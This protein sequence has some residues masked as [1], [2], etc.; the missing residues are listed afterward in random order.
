M[1][2]EV[3]LITSS[4]DCTIT[5]CCHNN[6]SPCNPNST[7]HDTGSSQWHGASIVHST[8]FEDQSDKARMPLSGADAIL[9]KLTEFS[10]RSYRAQGNVL[11]LPIS[12]VVNFK[13]PP[14]ARTFE[15][16]VKGAKHHF[17][18]FITRFPTPNLKLGNL[19]LVHSSY[20]SLVAFGTYHRS[21]P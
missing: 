1:S 20:I 6:T 9:R 5:E 16:A 21:P 3:L 12:K 4:S 13:Q 2:A 7:P 11:S 15:N 14:S 10:L 8:P 18:G 17:M 19:V